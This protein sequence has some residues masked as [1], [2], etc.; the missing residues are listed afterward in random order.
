MK[1]LTEK[2]TQRAIKNVCIAGVF[3]LLI[4]FITE[5]V[6]SGLALFLFSAMINDK[7]DNLFDVIA[8]NQKNDETIK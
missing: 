2:K 1:K 3:A 6:G 7:I 8:D 4:G 5:S